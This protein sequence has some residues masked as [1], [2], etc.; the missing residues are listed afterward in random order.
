M[1]IAIKNSAA[2]LATAAIAVI[3]FIALFVWVGRAYLAGVIAEKPYLKNFQSAMRLDPGNAQY[4]LELGRTYQYSVQNANPALAIQNLIRSVEL[5][6][7]SPQAWLDL[8]RAYEFQGDNATAE[9]CMRRADTLAPNIPGYQWAIG[10]FF[11]LHN[12]VKESFKHFK[13]V[14]A[15]NVQGQDTGYERQI[16][17][18]AWKASGDGPL[19]LASLI[20]NQVGPEIDYLGFLLT[21]GRLSETSAV[22]NHLAAS[23]DKFPAS[24]MGLYLDV[25]IG[26]HQA[27]QAWKVWS[28]LR[29]KGLIPSTY[30][31]TVQNMVENGNFENPLLGFGF[32]WRVAAVSGIFVDLDDSVYHSPSKSLLIQFPGNQNPEY[33]NVYQFVPVVPGHHYH[34]S[35]YMKTDN[36]TTDSGPRIEVKDAYNPALLDK[37]SDQLIGTTPS[38]TPLSIDFE[39]GPKTSL[40][41]V[42]V[43]RAASQEFASQ[44]AGKVWVDDVTLTPSDKTK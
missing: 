8:G 10:N 12:N 43:A 38:W 2:R 33:H 7:Y 26:S 44:I 32:G 27:D 9:T 22:W 34:L 1:H 36:I 18:T 28:T 5:N 24:D 6:A 20:P 42:V 17:N 39:T 15:A 4:A 16:Y 23:P 11:L 40:V 14:L 35:A 3:I 29:E 19:I 41:V 25:L 37:Y 21:S 31:Q 30:L 13:K